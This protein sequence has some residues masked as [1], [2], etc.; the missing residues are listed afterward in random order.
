MADQKNTQVKFE[1]RLYVSGPA[2]GLYAVR[3]IVAQDYAYFATQ[4][5]A[6]AFIRREE[7]IEA[8]A[9]LGPASDAKGG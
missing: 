4:G 5:D 2:S 3:K 1:W 8:R 6:E 7:E 9:V